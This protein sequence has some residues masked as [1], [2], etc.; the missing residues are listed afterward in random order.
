VFC[1]FV[2]NSRLLGVCAFKCLMTAKV[3]VKR[4]IQS[5]TQCRKLDFSYVTAYELTFCPQNTTKVCYNTRT[6]R[7]ISINFEHF[8]T[9]RFATWTCTGQTDRQTVAHSVCSARH[10]QSAI[11]IGFNTKWQFWDLQFGGSRVAI[12][13]AGGTEL[14]FC[15][16]PKTVNSNL[17]CFPIWQVQ[18]ILRCHELHWGT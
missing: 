11:M 2:Y 5:A 13:S 4:E 7:N 14:Y 17:P 3:R 6:I 18:L 15:A 16:E 9:F 12:F 1:V 8:T 10:P